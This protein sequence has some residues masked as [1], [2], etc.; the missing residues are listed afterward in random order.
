MPYRYSVIRFVPDPAKGEF[1]NL[2]VLCG[3][4]EEGDWDFRVLSNLQRAKAIDRDTGYLPSALAFLGELE[5]T[6]SRDDE[7]F[8]VATSPMT[9]NRLLTMSDEMKNIV[10]LTR[11]TPVVADSAEQALGV[12]S[13]ELL[14]EGPS[15]KF[16]FEKK[17]RALSTTRRAYELARIPPRAIHRKRLVTSG[18]FDL[19]FDFAI[20]EDRIVQ[21]VQCW[22]FQLP[23]QA[24]LAEQVRAWAWVV[25]ELRLQGGEVSTA[26]GVLEA[27]KGLSV[28]AV[29]IPP[30]ADGDQAAF[31]EALAA[32]EETEVAAVTP[33]QSDMI[34]E[35]AMALLAA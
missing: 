31:E 11:P 34:A 1:V 2:G 12:L 14:V 20:G 10:Q 32:F 23:N 25:H 3:D 22:S 15:R 28:G 33:E 17:H 19:N 35:R 4:E 21:L 18:P 26:I 13:P 24:D 9:H 6:L 29:Y 7:M 5:A 27:E 30:T 16:P 8:P